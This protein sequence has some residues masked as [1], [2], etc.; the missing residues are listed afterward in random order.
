M[1]VCVSLVKVCWGACL[2]VVDIVIVVVVVDVVVVVLTLEELV[3][4]MLAVM[5]GT[6]DLLPD[7]VTFSALV[8]GSTW[9]RGLHFLD[10]TLG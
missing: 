9:Q 10:V 4:H 8:A 2:I 1:C 5:R 7:V 3:M 6:T